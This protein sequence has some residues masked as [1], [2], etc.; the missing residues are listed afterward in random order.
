MPFIERSNDPGYLA[1]VQRYFD[2][3]GEQMKGF[4][5]NDGGPVYMVQLDNELSHAGN[6]WEMVYRYGCAEENRGPS[7]KEDF[8]KHYENL[9]TMSLKAGIKPV[10]FCMTGWGCP[11][12]P[13][14][15]FVIG[16]GGYMY[17]GDPGKENSKLTAIKRAPGVDLPYVQAFIECGAA[18]SPARNGR[19][20]RPP[21]ESA[22]STAYSFIGGSQA[23]VISWYMYGGGIN[24]LHPIWGWSAKAANFTLMSYDYNAPLSEFGF[25]RPA[26]YD[27]R[28]FH[29][30]LLNFG[31]TF[32]DGAF[33]LDSPVVEPI[34]DKLRASVR[35]GAKDGGVV[36]LL[37]YGNIKPLSD[38]QA[39]IELKTKSGDVRIPAQGGLD[40]KNGDFAILPFNQEFEGGVK[41]ISATAQLHSKIV[42]GRD[43][44]VFCSTIR[45]Q[46]AEFILTLPPGA[47]LDTSGQQS[48]IDKNL[49]VTMTPSVDGQTAITLADGH[50]LV[51]V[52]LPG[53]LIRHSVEATIRGQ[54]TYLISDQDIV[55]NGDKVQ[56]TSL[57]PG[58][59]ELLAFPAVPWS[60]ATPDGN[61][62][63]FSRSKVS[64]KPV[65]IQAEIRK[66]NNAKWLVKLPESELAGLNDIHADVDFT[67][68]ICRIFDQGS[69]LPVA[70]QLYNKGDKWQVGLKQF[71]KALAGPGLVF[72]A[73]GEDGKV[74][75]VLKDG[76]LMDEERQGQGFG[77]IQAIEFKPEYQ[78]WLSAN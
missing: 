49:R 31:D 13:T 68:L 41:L 25:R 70:D 73:T 65:E 30:T 10:Y 43:T 47:K 75:A 56:L 36:F 50:R 18:G 53:A 19:V 74:K 7:T 20:P 59:F 29:Q 16:M 71:R 28:P 60:G 34:E 8:I 33:V 51:F 5:W 11:G 3:M 61:A 55:V 24:P 21:V 38:R 14:N 22:M 72:Y 37:H 35:L 77:K 69:G 42:N 39:A 23:L 32:A 76:L 40:L 44:V 64:V 17:L 9:R 78:A 48:V 46:P 12:Y 54:K 66:V 45:D 67:G 58:E 2:A 57:K 62:G 26:Y 6:A 15:S 27:L 52:P 4:F 63:L 1:C